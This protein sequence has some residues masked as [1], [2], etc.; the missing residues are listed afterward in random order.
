VGDGRT[1]RPT[2]GP[3]DGPTQSLIEVLFA[4]KKRDTSLE[5]AFSKTRS[6]NLDLLPFI[7]LS[8]FFHLVTLLINSGPVQ[9]L[10]EKETTYTFSGDTSPWQGG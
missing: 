3:T 7:V 10:F 5:N 2:D 9:S 6:M 4:P 8:S 1:D